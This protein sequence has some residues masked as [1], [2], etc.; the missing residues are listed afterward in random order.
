MKHERNL[1]WAQTDEDISG[2]SRIVAINGDPEQWVP[3]RTATTQYI[4]APNTRWRFVGLAFDYGRQTVF[5]SD[6][7]N[8]KIQGLQLNGTSQPFVVFDGISNQ[9]EGVAVD[10]LVGNIYWADALYNWI[11]MAPAVPDTR[12]FRII[13]ST[14]LEHPT[15][16]AVH[17]YQ[18][19]ICQYVL[20]RQNK[21]ID[22]HGHYCTFQISRINYNVSLF[23]AVVFHNFCNV[24]TEFHSYEC[25]KQAIINLISF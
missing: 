13:I 17:P 3:N 23:Q 16:L 14:G 5:W 2:M 22:V 10:W 9:V 4:T 24:N 11:V 19:Y 6:T 25:Y 12:L 18:G 8:K 20:L 21:C 7:G 15:G 1:I